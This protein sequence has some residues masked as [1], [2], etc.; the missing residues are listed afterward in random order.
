MPG[1]ELSSFV[2]KVVGSTVG[3]GSAV[4]TLAPS[5]TAPGGVFH[6]G[7]I[8]RVY[9]LSV[10]LPGGSNTSLLSFTHF[11]SPYHRPLASGPQARVCPQEKKS[12]RCCR[13][14][15]HNDSEFIAR[16]SLSLDN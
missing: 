6:V 1:V 14:E 13:F 9:S 2:P 3:K 15:S 16:N 4:R 7:S 8:P 12:V 5:Y 11:C 10:G